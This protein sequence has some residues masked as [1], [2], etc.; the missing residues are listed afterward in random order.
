M[1]LAKALTVLLIATTVP[2]CAG[3]QKKTAMTPDLGTVENSVYRNEFFGM[4]LTIPDGWSVKSQEEL[5]ANAEKGIRAIA[6]DDAVLGRKLKS[7][8]KQVLYPLGAS[9]HPLGSPVLINPSIL[10]SAEN[11][12]DQPDITSGSDCNARA[13]KLLEMIDLPL[14]FSEDTT[15]EQFGG[16]SFDIMTLKMAV[17]DSEVKQKYY[18]AIIKGYELG[19][20]ITYESDE[21]EAT[22]NEVLQSIAFN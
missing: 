17:R 11:V 10:I 16:T 5:N 22:F 2:L 19:I 14:V 4:T 12:S 9:K 7:E 13:R 18:A 15:T 6:G 1:K 21:E 3:C 8:L 20:V